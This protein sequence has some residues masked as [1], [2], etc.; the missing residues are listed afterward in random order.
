[1]LLQNSLV[2]LGLKAMLA[3]FF[4]FMFLAAICSIGFLLAFYSLGEG[5]ISLQEITWCLIK[6]F[7]GNSYSEIICPCS[8]GYN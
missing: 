2:L 3:D 5:R 1:M 4:A 8:R 7:L 6:V